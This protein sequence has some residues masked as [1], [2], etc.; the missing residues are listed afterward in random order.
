ME[1]IVRA[2]LISALIALCP[3]F[4]AAQTNATPAVAQAKMECRRLV[5]GQNNFIESNE[6]VINGMACH[7]VKPVVV[8]SATAPLPVAPAAKPA[9]PPPEATICFYR[10]SALMGAAIHPSIFIDDTDVGSLGRGKKFA[11]TVS[12]GKHSIHST[13]KGS[14]IDLDAKA[15]ETY[16]VRVGFEVDF[17]KGHGTV[18]LVSPQQ[19]EYEAA[20]MS[21]ENTQ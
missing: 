4:V 13:A 19:G 1:K 20:K 16:Y 11:L 9:A 12:A 17:L 8:A 14:D 7:V 10:T 18:T 5:P 2:I 3:A 21:E 15:G 6:T